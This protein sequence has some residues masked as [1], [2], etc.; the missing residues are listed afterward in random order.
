MNRYT[1]GF[2]V[3]LI[4]FDRNNGRL[5]EARDRIPEP[6]RDRIFILGA[7]SEPEDL[8]KAGLGIYEAIGLAMARD[9]REETEEIWG[10]ELLRHNAGELA[11]LREQVR[12]I[13]F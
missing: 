12:P 7:R 1:N 5:D 9:C 10:H 2:I 4:D 8:K 6:L 13:L 11:R 3:L